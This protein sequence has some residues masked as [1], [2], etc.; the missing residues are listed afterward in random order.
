MGF[1]SCSH[2]AI[3]QHGAAI[4]L[5]PAMIPFTVY[6]HFVQ[7]LVAFIKMNPINGY[8]MF[9]RE[10]KK[11]LHFSWF[12]RRMVF[13]IQSWASESLFTKYGLWTLRLE[14]EQLCRASHQ[15]EKKGKNS[16]IL[17]DNLKVAGFYACRTSPRCGQSAWWFH[18][19]TFAW[20]L[21]RSA[22]MCR[23]INMLVSPVKHKMRLTLLQL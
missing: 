6:Y 16:W 19:S 3:I 17:I 13:R 8:F 14:S 2:T 23:A 1:D 18:C 11:V 20:T 22:F 7:S 5:L 12:N 9:K 15:L 4:T 10:K 21:S